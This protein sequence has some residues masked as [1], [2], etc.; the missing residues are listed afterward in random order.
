VTPVQTK[1]S[2]T[3]AR[4]TT[5]RRAA[6]ERALNAE[7]QASGRKSPRSGA[8]RTLMNVISQLPAF[9]RLLG[10]LFLDRRVAALDKLVVAGAIAYIVSPIDL[11]PDFIPFLGEVDDV[12]LLV[13]ALQRMFAN[14]GGRVLADHWQGSISDLRNMDLQRILSAAAFFL[15]R[16]VRRRLRMI[17]R[18]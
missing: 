17:G 18:G 14:A 16:R 15:P 7:E 3:R 6:R 9:L 12:Y 11:V 8:K 1:R 5:S 4:G 2:T 10:G 13:L